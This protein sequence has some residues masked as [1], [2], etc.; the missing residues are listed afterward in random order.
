MRETL[1]YT[2]LGVFPTPIHHCMAL[3]KHLRMDALYLKRDDVTGPIYGGNKVRKLEF[4]LGKA[5][6]D[7]AR[8]V[9]TFGFTGSNHALATTIYAREVG[10][11]SISMFMPQPNSESLRRNLLLGHYFGAELHEY[12]GRQVLSLA[13]AY[14]MCRHAWKMGRRPMLIPPGGSSPL[15]IMGIV[16]A[17][18]ELRDQIREG[19]LPEPA[20][21]Y[22]AVGSMGTAVGLAIGLRAA[23]LG[24]TVVPVRVIHPHL[25]NTNRMSGLARDTVRFLQNS[26]PHFPTPDDIGSEFTLR[27]EFYG[28]QYA[29]YTQAGMD[30]IRLL[31][32]TE[33]VALDGTYSGKAMA[34]LLSDANKGNLRGKVVLFWDTYNSRPVWDTVPLPEYHQLPH[35]FHKYFENPVQPLDSQ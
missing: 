2:P 33:G 16:N 10:L 7:G 31:R 18:F 35:R 30:A 6:R 32:E 13:T 29:L 3:G 22:V 26:D 25:A 24:C 8:E 17:A 15:G 20:Y 34:A 19:I 23:G 28:E 1:P 4:L 9:M 21:I 12:P 14:Q 11:R 5:L 27:E